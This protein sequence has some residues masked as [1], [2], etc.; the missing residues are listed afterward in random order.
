MRAQTLRRSGI[1]VTAAVAALAACKRGERYGNRSDTTAATSTGAVTDTSAGR[2]TAGANANARAGGGMSDANIAAV[3]DAANES[4]SAFGALAVR[5]GRSADVKNFGRLMMGEH[6]ALRLQGQQLVKR[7]NV[8]PQPPANFDLPNK[9]RDAMNDLQGKSGADFDKS[10]IDHEVDY[11]KQVLQT[12]QQ[13]LDQ[14]QNAELKD[15]IRKAAPVIQR[16]L[17]RAEQIQKRLGT[18][19]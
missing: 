4:D 10:Y 19:A 7:L 1:L 2:A 5:K 12:A 18:R 9:Q 11:H 16:H 14:A 17:D 8:T 3:L 6:H 13:A 15:L